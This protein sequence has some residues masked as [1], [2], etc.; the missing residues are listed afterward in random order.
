MKIFFQRYDGKV[1]FSSKFIYG[2]GRNILIVAG[3]IGRPYK[4]LFKYDLVGCL[5]SIVLFSFLGYFLGHSYLLL[6]D[7]IKGI[8]LIVIVLILTIIILERLK[9]CQ[10]FSKNNSLSSKY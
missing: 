7:L 6:N 10:I 9:V 3:F 5:L 2:L 8:G 1:V 4:K